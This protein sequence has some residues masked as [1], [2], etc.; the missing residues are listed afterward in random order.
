MR[1]KSFRHIKGELDKPY[2]FHMCS[3]NAERSVCPLETTSKII[4]KIHK[5]VISPVKIT[6]LKKFILLKIV[7]GLKYTIT[8]LIDPTYVK[9]IIQGQ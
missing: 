5:L 7:T 1:G 6:D 9:K 4:N 8:K 3:N 2:T